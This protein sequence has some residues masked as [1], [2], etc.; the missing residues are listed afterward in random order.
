MFPSEQHAIKVSRTVSFLALMYEKIRNAVEYREEHLIRRAAIERILKRR[1][2]L[3][4]EG[5]GIAEPLI[6]E[7]LWA[8][9]L[10][11][12]SIPE[13]K[14]AVVQ[15]S[16][17]KYLYL[18]RSIV[19][20]RPKKELHKIDQFIVNLMSC[21]IEEI[22]APAP[23]REAF[24]NF[25]YHSILN[26]VDITDKKLIT[27]KNI[28]VYIA[29]EQGFAKSDIPLVHYHLIKILLPEL[30]DQNTAIPTNALPHFMSVYS[31][32]EN[33]LKLGINEKLRRFVKKNSAPFL[34]IRDLIESRVKEARSIMNDENQLRFRV[35]EICRKRYQETKKRLTRAGV[36]SIIYIF[37]TKMI[38]AILLEYPIDKYLEAK[39]ALMPLLI[40]IIAPPFLMFLLVVITSVPGADNTRR[41]FDR[42]LTI[43]KSDTK[44]PEK[45][46][47]RDR[48]IIR[49]PILAFGFSIIYLL[50]F[51]LTFGSIF[52]V[53]SLLKF[54]I[55]SQTIFIFFVSLVL[56]FGY[57]IRQTAKEYLLVEKEGILSPIKD[58]FMLPVL[59]LGKWLSSEIGRLNFFIFI[60]DFIIEAPF[61]AI[62]EIGEEWINFMKSKKEEFA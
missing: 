25:V 39:V 33:I 55:A 31:H 1:M 2:M 6:K 15:K 16:I 45:I 48:S 21:E 7:L 50:A 23:Q 14:I 51:F 37:L 53:L 11:S 44:Q 41:I 4:D 60:F 49:R 56:F 3:N 36:R 57:R 12:L 38:L 47:I 46:I 26:L 22:L 5:K 40:N 27:E 58:F 43:I 42:L 24:I 59:S 30:T 35:D 32:I 17:N 61:K 52:F 28:L 8:R 18:R 13:S 9:Y 34:I 19:P 29:V 62:F 54:N 20:G 10:Q